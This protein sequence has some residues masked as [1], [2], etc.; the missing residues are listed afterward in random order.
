MAMERDAATRRK[1]RPYRRDDI[2]TAAVKL[3]HENG[4][5]ATGMDDIGAATGITGPA[6]YRHFRNKEEILETLVLERA[7]AALEEAR[8]IVDSSEAEPSQLLERL[9]EHYVEFLLANPALAV[10]AGYE[11]RTLRPE[12]RGQITRMERLYQEEWVQALSQRRPELSDAEA[13]VMVRAAHGLGVSAASYK[14]GLDRASLA[15][16]VSQMILQALGV[17]RAAARPR[18]ARAA[19]AAAAR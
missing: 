18:A 8:E 2:L 6:I 16:L 9:I 3:F 19:R 17:G 7:S 5:H 4:Y 10:V 15:E 12:V 13:K 1:R 11:P 14:S